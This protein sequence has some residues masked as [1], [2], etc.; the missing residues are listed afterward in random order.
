MARN[1]ERDSSA[2]T[3]RTY[4]V[5]QILEMT[6]HAETFEPPAD[7]HLR[8]YWQTSVAEFRDNLYTQTAQ[9]RVT[10]EGLSKLR[11]H[12]AS[13]LIDLTTQNADAPDSAGWLEIEIPIET[14]E[15]AEGLLLSLGADVEVL[16]PVEL[17]TRILAT[18]RAIADRHGRASNPSQS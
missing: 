4:R 13:P 9:V 12:P 18:S 17:R 14:L 5:N 6:T 1:P 15:H 8:T 2:S 16:R 10:I 11:Q 3:I 7:F